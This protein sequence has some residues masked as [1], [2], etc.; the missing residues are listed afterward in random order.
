MD[1]PIILA[2]ASPRR[3]ELLS[4]IGLPYEVHVPEVD[5]SETGSPD[6]IVLRLAQKKARAAAAV[7][8]GRVILAADTLV[9]AKGEVLGLDAAELGRF[10]DPRRVRVV[11]NVVDVEDYAVTGVDR[12]A[13]TVVFP[14]MFG[15]PPNEDAARVLLD[16]IAPRLP[17]WTVLLAGSFIPPWLR[18]RAG[19]SCASYTPPRT[20]NLA[21]YFL[22]TSPLPAT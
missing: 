6:G 16:D 21:P 17:G 2:S 14:A 3:H 9:Y 22:N 13:R 19:P 7:Y 12:R 1:E 8:P 18:E 11:P 15:Y 10:A 4:M 5:E 20:R